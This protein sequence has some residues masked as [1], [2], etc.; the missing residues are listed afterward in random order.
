M[1]LLLAAL[2]AATEPELSPGFEHFY[3]LEYDQAIAY[4]ER[5]LQ[6]RPDDPAAHNHLAQGLLFR[7][8]FRAGALESELVSGANPF[9]RRPKI[10]TP[11]EITARFETAIQ[12]SLELSLQRIHTDPRDAT[13]HYTAG[14]AYGL[15]ANFNFLVR[16]AWLDA[17]RDATQARKH[18]NLVTDIDPNMLDARL[19]QGLHDYVVGSLPW[20]WRM[21]GFLAGIRGD[22]ER[23]IQTLELVARQGRMNRYDAQVLLCAIYRREKQSQKAIPLL[24]SLIERFPRNFLFRLELAQM[25]G[26]LGQ[27][28]EALAVLAEAEELKRRNAPGFALMPI[29]KVYFYRGNLLFWQGDLENALA[30]LRLVTPKAKQLDFNTGVISWLRIGQIY[31]L[32]GRRQEALQAYR[33][34][35]DVAPLSDAAQE[36]RRYLNSPY[37]R[38]A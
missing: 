19:V 22:R 6:Q 29:E 26:D 1:L 14:V 17:L 15:R 5:E 20:T 34:A 9:L 27:K 13:A 3:N 10:T 8:L 7:E 36:A 11:P 28:A 16:K 38:P 12:R 18:H 32:Q 23:G 2:F 25:H 35:I 24:R 4:F 37:R 31:D 21:L 33:N 30:Q